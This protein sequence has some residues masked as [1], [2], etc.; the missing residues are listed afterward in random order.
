VSDRAYAPGD[1]LREVK[2]RQ[3]VM[4]ACPGHV[5]VQDIDIRN[6]GTKSWLCTVCGERADASWV[7]A[8]KQGLLHAQ[9][10][11]AAEGLFKS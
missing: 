9:R 11:H 8:Y 10:G 2:R 1:V 7:Y 5:F 6:H 3:A 4:E